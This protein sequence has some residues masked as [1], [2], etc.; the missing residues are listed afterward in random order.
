M[1]LTYVPA[2]SLHAKKYTAKSTAAKILRSYI[3]N[4]LSIRVAA[5]T[6]PHCSLALKA[7]WGKRANSQYRSGR[8]PDWVK[9]R[10][11][12]RDEFV[13]VGW[14]PAKGN[15]DD[16]GS[17]ALA[18]YRGDDLCYA[19]HAGSGLGAKL[20]DELVKRVHRLARKTSPLTNSRTA[21]KQSI[22][23]APRL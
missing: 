21:S 5:P 4:T 16:I 10:N 18:E 11:Q 17:L 2:N 3:P 8:S 19:G 15:A 22:G 1:G 9:V 20:R 6:R 7:W 23:Y 12:R 14:S 13:V